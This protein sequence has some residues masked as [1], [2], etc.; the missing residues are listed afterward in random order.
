[1]VDAVVSISSRRGWCRLFA[2]RWGNWYHVREG[3]YDLRKIVVI[4]A[5]IAIECRSQV[6]HRCL[7]GDRCIPLSVLCVRVGVVA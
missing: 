5:K 3:P 1:M 2:N 6:C 4:D 7:R